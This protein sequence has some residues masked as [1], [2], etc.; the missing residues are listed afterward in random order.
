MAAG[1][2]TER[3]LSGPEY[4]T[5]TSAALGASITSTYTWVIKQIIFCNTDGTDRLVYLSLG[6]DSTDTSSSASSP[7]SKAA[8]ENRIFHALPIAANDTVVLDCALV[9][10]GSATA[11]AADRLWGYA[12]TAS[13]VTVTV[14]G[15]RKEN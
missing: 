5:A 11:A 8:P 12:D 4:L 13:K 15:W 1:D 6:N 14:V 7:A 2:R 3:R 9:L 10:V